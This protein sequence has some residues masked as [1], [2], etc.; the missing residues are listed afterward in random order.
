HASHESV[1]ELLVP[2][3]V[4]FLKATARVVGLEVVGAL[5]VEGFLPR[6]L[7]LHG[8]R[9][10]GHARRRG[11]PAR[12][13]RAPR[14]LL[15]LVAGRVRPPEVRG[16]AGQTLDL[17][18]LAGLHR[19][20]AVVQDEA[21]L[22]AI[23]VDLARYFQEL[24]HIR[25]RGLYSR[26]RRRSR[27]RSSPATGPFPSTRSP[28][29]PVLFICTSAFTS[30]FGILDLSS[31]ERPSFGLKRMVVLISNWTV[32]SIFCISPARF[33]CSRNSR[34]SLAT[35]RKRPFFVSSTCARR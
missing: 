4:A 32:V 27:G 22:R 3:E 6:L 21:T 11:G 12:A 14:A 34:T 30:G 20:D 7:V 15:G 28:A 25:F 35:T 19:D 18:R 13:L 1:S 5:A 2:Q 31:P 10:A 26:L 17:M 8:G 23:A 24:G 33:V 29:R 16:A 9:D